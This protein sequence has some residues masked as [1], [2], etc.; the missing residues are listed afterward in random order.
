MDV[1]F[2]WEGGRRQARSGGRVRPKVRLKS[3]E[4]LESWVRW[5]WP[6]RRSRWWCHRRMSTRLSIC[7]PKWQVPI[8]TALFQIPRASLNLQV[9]HPWI[10]EDLPRFCRRKCQC[11]LWNSRKLIIHA[12]F[13]WNVQLLDWGG[14]CWS[15][16]LG[17]LRYGW[18]THSFCPSWRKQI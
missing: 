5:W 1:S 11:R 6:T 2:S 10:G 8:L 4:E 15:A 17:F 7:M 3:C 12:I 18:R 9:E 13:W 14:F 16:S